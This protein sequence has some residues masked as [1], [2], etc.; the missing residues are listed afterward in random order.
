M[1]SYAFG[2]WDDAEKQF[3]ESLVR[4]PLNTYVLWNLGY[5]Y[6]AAGRFAESEAVYRKLLEI[7]PDFAWA[8]KSLG[9]TLLATAT[10]KRHLPLWSKLSTR[11]TA[12]SSPFFCRQSVARPR[13]T[14]R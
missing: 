9:K 13:Q 10:R 3:Q 14:R 11:G 5:T 7:A 2:H 12:V 1:L 6:Y 4:D 8:R